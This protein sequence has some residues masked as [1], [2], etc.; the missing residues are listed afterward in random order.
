LDFFQRFK[1]SQHWSFT[2][3]LPPGEGIFDG[4]CTVKEVQQVTVRGLESSSWFSMSG[5]QLGAG[6]RMGLFFHPPFG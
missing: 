1:G 6:Q 5:C 4:V 2:Q 3:S